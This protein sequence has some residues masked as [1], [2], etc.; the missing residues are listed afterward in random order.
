MPGIL[1]NAGVLGADKKLTDSAKKAILKRLAAAQEKG[2][3]DSPPVKKDLQLPDDILD[4]KKYPEFHKE[5]FGQFEAVVNSLDQQGNFSLPPPFMDPL[6]LAAKLNPNPDLKFN[7]A[8]LPTLNPINLALII[9]VSPVDFMSKLS[10]PPNDPDAL[11]KPPLP[12]FKLPKYLPDP[13]YLKDLANISSPFPAPGF[14]KAFPD[15]IEYDLWKS[16]QLGIPAAFAKIIEELL[17]DPSQILGVLQPKPKLDFA[18]N[19]IRKAGIFGKSDKGEDTKAAA[20]SVLAQYTGEAA[21]IVATG[22]LIGDGG[23]NGGTGL[24]AR[25]IEIVV[26]EVEVE[27]A[28]FVFDDPSGAK[29]VQIVK[30]FLASSNQIDNAPSMSKGGYQSIGAPGAAYPNFVLAPGYK[31]GIPEP[32]KYGTVATS[33]GLL[34]PTC[35]DVL[36]GKGWQNSSNQT[37][38]SAGESVDAKRL[39]TPLQE[40]KENNDDFKISSANTTI[41][42]GPAGCLAFGKITRSYVPSGM[43]ERPEPGDVYFVGSGGTVEHT[44]LIVG[45]NR[46]GTKITGDLIM[47]ADAGQGAAG[48]PGNSNLKV[49]D[50]IKVAGTKVKITEKNIE[51][52]K[53]GT[54]SN[55]QSGW[56]RKGWYAGNGSPGSAVMSGDFG[57]GAAQAASKGGS[58]AARPIIGWISIKKL[59]SV[60]GKC[61]P[62]GSANPEEQARCRQWVTDAYEKSYGNLSKIYAPDIVFDEKVATAEYYSVNNPNNRSSL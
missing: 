26:D 21:G 3:K 50:E 24:C 41:P 56:F 49:G 57:A 1:E 45:G 14:P 13:A 55:Q 38:N 23:K 60:M 18:V 34:T 39:P 61:T 59:L 25:S 29:M 40:A 22:M 15:K 9:D 8:Q 10:L 58:K 33:C 46:V 52:Y 28:E 16:P 43:K 35:L 4:E 20:Q 53:K 37:V 42:K 44:G 54:P 11:I 62:N 7:Y 47:T 48:T 6:A 12:D 19:A 31:D 36:L 30:S 5:V 32:T 27:E 51:Q 2:S 17:K